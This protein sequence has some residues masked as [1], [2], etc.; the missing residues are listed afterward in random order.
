MLAAIYRTTGSSDVLSVEEVETPRPGAGEVLV[1]LTV[2]GVNPTDF[3]SR[4]GSTGDLGF[5]FQVPGQDGAGVIEAVGEGVDASREGQRVWVYFAAWQRQWGTAAQVTVLPAE[6]AVPLPDG[7][8]DE[9][10]A[11]LGIP[12]LTA[13][14]CLLADGPIDG[15]TVL[16]AGGA[17]AVGHAA[18]E[19][20]KWAGARVVA[21]VSNDEKAELARTAGADAVVNYKADDA[22]DQV[23]AAAPDGVDRVVELALGANLELDVA[24]AAPNAIVTS[25]ANDADAPTLDVRTLMVPN[26]TLRFMLVY[27]LPKPALAHA[28]QDV[29]EAVADG[30]LTPLPVHRFPLAETAA[31]HDAVEGGAVGK[32][33]IDLP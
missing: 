29:S 9:L 13:H 21:T 25:Y 20:A 31:A 24:V 19:L 11:S 15:G 27:T 8:S 12:A 10:G 18:I 28:V 1:R 3:K 5:P 33:V 14:H 32:V 4:A 7:A 26:L 16:V 23:K 6:Q 22:V 30:A 2:A 17:G